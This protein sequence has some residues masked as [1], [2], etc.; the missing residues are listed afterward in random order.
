MIINVGMVLALLPVIGIP[1]PLVSY[2]G[3]ALVPSLVALGLLVGFARREP[4]AAAALRQRRRPDRPAWPRVGCRAGVSDPTPRV[5]PDCA[6]SSPAAAPPATPLRC[7]R[8]PTPC[9]GSSR[10][11]RSPAWAPPAGLETRVVPEAGYPLEL[12]A[13]VPFPRRPG[14]DLLQVPGRLR[15]A[16]REAARGPRPG[17]ARRGRRLRR[18]RLDAGLPRRPAPQGA[19]SCVHEQ[20]AVP[21]LAN[22]VGAR[23]ARRVAVS[24]PDTP[25]PKAEYVG[26]PIR[27]MISGLDRAAL[28]A[29]ARALL[30]PR[31]RPADPAGHRWLAGRPQPQ[32][33]G[34][35]R[36]GRARRRRRAGAARRRPA[37]TRRT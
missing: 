26:L 1:L 31:P 3:S 24:F 36:R 2:G 30:R 13:P 20:N 32:P 37:G 15:G 7:W 5:H 4:E 29:E 10:T 27:T 16:V 33:G 23:I 35:R 9:A 8:P 19:P 28:R 14:L 11:S 18:L 25:L 17:P 22:K 21:G 34:L 6:Y 12:I